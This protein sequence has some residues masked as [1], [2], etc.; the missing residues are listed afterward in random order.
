MRKSITISQKA[1]DYLAALN[2]EAQAAQSRFQ[3][4]LAVLLREHDIPDSAKAD[5][6]LDGP[7]LS[8]EEP[9]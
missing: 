6:K 1:S 9:E 4:A 5:L 2:A 7:E 3:A 8:W